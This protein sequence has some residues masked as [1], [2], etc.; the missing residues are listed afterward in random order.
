MKIGKQEERVMAMTEYE[1]Y[2]KWAKKE[3]EGSKIGRIQFVN[4]Q[5]TFRR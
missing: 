4:P 5:V 3:I 2:V 1:N